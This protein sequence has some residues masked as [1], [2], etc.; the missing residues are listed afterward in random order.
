MFYSYLI[1]TL[2]VIHPFRFATPAEIGQAQ[3][4]QHTVLGIRTPASDGSSEL[5]MN[6]T[7]SANA[8]MLFAADFIHVEEAFSRGTSRQ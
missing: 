5:Y 6:S 1:T 8:T 3:G 2:S 4:T 7:L